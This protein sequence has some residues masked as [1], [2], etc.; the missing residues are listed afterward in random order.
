M[1]ECNLYSPKQ[2]RFLH[3]FTGRRNAGVDTAMRCFEQA[4][5]TVMAVETQD[6]QIFFCT[7]LYLEG[8]FDELC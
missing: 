5:Q 4:D 1:R 8:V 7:V 6:I 3:D 2:K